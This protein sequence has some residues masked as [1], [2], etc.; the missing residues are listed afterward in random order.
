LYP[1]VFRIA[2]NTGN[3]RMGFLAGEEKPVSL[4][5]ERRGL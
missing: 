5:C 1:A 3:F 4:F 2:A